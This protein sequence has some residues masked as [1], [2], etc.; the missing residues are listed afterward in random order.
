[1][2]ARYLFPDDYMADLSVHVFNG[3]LYISP[4][5]DIETGAVF[6][7]DGG[8]FQMRDYHVLSLS[9]SPLEAHVTDHGVILY[10]S[11][12]SWAEK[13]MWDNDAWVRDGSLTHS[14]SLSAYCEVPGGSRLQRTE[15]GQICPKRKIFHQKR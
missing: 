7:D 10:V 1:M 3:R 11:Q 9:G 14:D 8:H 2:K 15:Y 12:V 13:Q 5:H 4:S 6:D